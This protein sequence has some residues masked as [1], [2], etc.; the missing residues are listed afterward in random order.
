MILIGKSHEGRKQ[1]ETN[2]TCEVKHMHARMHRCTHTQTHT[3]KHTRTYTQMHVQKHVHT[4][5]HTHKHI[6]CEKERERTLQRLTTYPFNLYRG[7]QKSYKKHEWDESSINSIAASS[8]V[9]WGGGGGL[10]FFFLFLPHSPFPCQPQTQFQYVL[11][12][13]VKFGMHI[14]KSLWQ[15]HSLT[16]IKFSH[17][18]NYLC[19][20]PKPRF[21]TLES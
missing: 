11:H 8:L 17:N 14:Y 12:I 5:T 20:L 19:V 13:F 10:F 6:R 18:Y 2:Y 9:F 1:Q 3:H 21:T 7:C 15:R 16:I 4:H